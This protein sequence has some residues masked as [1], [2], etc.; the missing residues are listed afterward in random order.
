MEFDKEFYKSLRLSS[1][2]GLSPGWSRAIIWTNFFFIIWNNAEILLIGP[3]GTNFCEILIEIHTFSFKKIHL[4]MLSVKW[5]PFCLSLDMI[6]TPHVLLFKIVMILSRAALTHSMLPVV[7]LCP[8][9]W[10]LAQRHRATMDSSAMFAS[11]WT[12]SQPRCEIRHSMVN[13]LW[14][15]DV[16]WWQGSRSTLAQVMACCLTAPSHYLPQCWLMISKVLWH[17]PDRNF[18]ENT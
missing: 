12:L 18:T 10:K 5:R 15:R 16:I 3:L 1:D 11:W 8:C 14:P 7:P 2:N 17:S 4:K 9:R 13:S 6:R